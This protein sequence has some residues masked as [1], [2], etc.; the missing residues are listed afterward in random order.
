MYLL[1]L[2]ALFELP[3]Y[4][5]MAN[6]PPPA[7]NHTK[8]LPR[9]SRNTQ[10]FYKAKSWQDRSK[11]SQDLSKIFQDLGKILVRQDLGKIFNE[12]ANLFFL[13]C[14]VRLHWCCKQKPG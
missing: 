8:I 3:L 10:Y 13:V 9:S 7:E 4:S 12:E 11:T 5:G 1:T 6:V 2:Q 14:S